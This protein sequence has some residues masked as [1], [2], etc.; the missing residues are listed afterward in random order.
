MTNNGSA[1]EYDQLARMSAF[2]SEPELEPNCK[3]SGLFS[4]LVPGTT[5][6]SLAAGSSV[7]NSGSPGHDQST[8]DEQFTPVWSGPFCPVR[9]REGRGRADACLPG[10]RHEQEDRDQR[11]NDSS[12]SLPC[13]GV[14]HA[15]YATWV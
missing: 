5:A 8:T 2:E 4:V 13:S 7:A 9:R 6:T 14:Q 3:L 12:E 15:S 11:P 10:S 1:N